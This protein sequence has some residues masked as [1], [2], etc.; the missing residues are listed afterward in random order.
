MNTQKNPDENFHEKLK[1][2]VL[3]EK[4]LQDL[5]LTHERTMI[6]LQ[7]LQQLTETQIASADSNEIFKK[8]I[9]NLVSELR[10][11][12][13]GV[14]EITKNN[15][16]LV[17]DHVCECYT[18]LDREININADFIEQVRQQ[19]IL[20]TNDLDNPS[21]ETL[22]AEGGNIQTLLGLGRFLACVINPFEGYSRLMIVG[23]LH[24]EVT[25]SLDYNNEDVCYFQMSAKSVEDAI[26]HSYLLK[27]LSSERSKLKVANETLE[28]RVREQTKELRETNNSLEENLIQLKTAQQ[29]LVEASKLSALGQMAGG[30]AHEINNPLAIISCN[31]NMLKELLLEGDLE[32]N[33]ALKITEK[34]LATTDRI[35]KI[36]V[37][38]KAFSREGQTDLFSPTSLKG[39]VDN[40]VALCFEKFKFHGIN[41]RVELPEEDVT[42][43]CRAVQISQVLLNLLS[44]AF[45]AA[46][47]GSEKWVAIN[48]K[49]MGDLVEIEVLDSGPG[50]KPEIQSKIFQPFFTT[51]DF[52]HGTGL[53]LSVSLGVVMDHGG[54][55][56]LDS[57]ASNTRFVI[58]L[59]LQVSRQKAQSVA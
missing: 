33:M 20:L 47:K 41:I 14:F 52:G 5:G 45:D 55:L 35:A 7:V 50:V 24:N 59:P 18:N 54:K 44:N 32:K 48:F 42:I 1:L 57:K 4:Q 34:I 58:C 40:T 49:N 25:S 56:S 16:K 13:V 10:F 51:K 26:R 12:M 53:G 11:Q 3:R 39:I 21:Y 37:G 43:N 6:W 31:G 2:L 17:V 27:E 46:Q 28:S 19:R 23:H 22:K 36:I 38:L 8:W 30:V 9:D 15:T 29:Q